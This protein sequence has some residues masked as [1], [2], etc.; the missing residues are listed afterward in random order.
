MTDL[1]AV[2]PARHELSAVGLVT[3]Q[4]SWGGLFD[5]RPTADNYAVHLVRATDRGTPGPT[6]CGIDRFA[7]DAPGWS[8]GG[9]VSGPGIKHTPCQGC[10]DVARRDFRDL[11]IRGL[12]SPQIVACIAGTEGQ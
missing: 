11:P 8:V 6:L 3:L 2:M 9:G 12:G 4:T 7:D 5:P 10:A 1:P